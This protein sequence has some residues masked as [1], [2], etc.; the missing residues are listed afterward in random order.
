MRVVT[1]ASNTRYKTELWNVNTEVDCFCPR[2]TVPSMKSGSGGVN[3][4]R[5]SIVAEAQRNV[6][7]GVGRPRAWSARERSLDPQMVPGGLRCSCHDT[8]SAFHPRGGALTP[9]RQSL[10]VVAHCHRSKD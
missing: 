8:S 3:V 5:L 7:G 6:R 2:R 10:D 9:R 1:S 4:A